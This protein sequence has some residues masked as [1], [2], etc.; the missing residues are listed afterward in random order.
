MPGS[1]KMKNVVVIGAR[2]AK[3]ERV[4][5]VCPTDWKLPAHV[6]H[7]AVFRIGQERGTVPPGEKIG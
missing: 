4:D 7:P 2:N 1:K 5:T 3:P 6:E